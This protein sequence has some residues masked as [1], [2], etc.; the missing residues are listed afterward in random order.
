LLYL[1]ASTAGSFCFLTQFMR[2]HSPPFLFMISWIFWSK[3]ECFI[4]LTVF[5]NFFQSSKL[6][7]NLY[8]LRSLLQFKSYQ[9]F[10]C[11]VILTIFKFLSYVSSMMLAS[12]LTTFSNN[13]TLVKL[14]VSI[15]LISL[16]KLLMKDF[17]F[18]LPLMIDCFLF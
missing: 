12:K 11:M 17:S 3:N 10:E 2:S 8:F 15:A 14:F 5:L 7:V 9:L 4:L 1:I 18:S 16:I 13:S 6:L